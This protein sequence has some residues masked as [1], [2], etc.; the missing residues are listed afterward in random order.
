[1]AF[2]RRVRGGLRGL[3]PQLNGGEP[4][5]LIDGLGTEPPGNRRGFLHK[6]IFGAIRSVASIGSV[7]GIPGA[8]TVSR[9]AGRIAGTPRVR[10]LPITIPQRTQLGPPPP[11]SI[12]PQTFIPN[13][14][15]TTFPGLPFVGSGGAAAGPCAD[16][17]L[18]RSPQGNCIFPG[19][20]RGAAVFGGNVIAGQYGAGFV[21][22]SRIVDVADCPR[23]TVLGKDGICYANLA[24]KNRLYPRG[25]RPLLTGGDMRAISRARSAGNRL[26]NAKSDLLAIGMLK[27]AGPRKRRKKSV[28]PC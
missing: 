2:V 14:T 27:A 24:N 6:K 16:P 23:G 5:D 4:M 28:P 19:S 12:I 25:R 22:G 18:V 17:R 1:M 10:T 11:V 15:S 20:P 21:A 3:T 8:S 9:I 13:V 26:A 7:I